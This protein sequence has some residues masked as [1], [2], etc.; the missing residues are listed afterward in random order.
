L[1]LSGADS[2]VQNEEHQGSD[3]LSASPGP[4]AGR[5][6]RALYPL[7]LAVAI[8]IW[9][10]AI[11]APLRIDE[12]GSYWQISKGFSEIVSRQG[13]LSFPAYSYIL[14][15]STKIIGT[16]EI[17]LRVPSILAM[18]GAVY[19][20]YLA[21][22]ELFER[23]IAFIAAVIFCLDPIVVF[24]SIDIRPYAF[25]VLATNAAIFVLLR[26]RHS[27]SNWLAALFG[28]MAASIVWFHFLFGVILPP[29]VLCFIAFKFR[30]CKTFWKQ[31]IV[32]SGAFALAFLPV[33]P[34]LIDMLRTSK[35]HVYEPA[36]NLSDLAMTLAPGW[37]F[38]VGCGIGFIAFL[39]HAVRPQ[40][41]LFNRFEGWLFLICASLGLLPILILYGVSAGTSLH[42][43]TYY[44]RLVAIPG[45]ALC[46]AFVLSRFH[47]RSLRLLFCLA[48][49]AATAYVYFTSPAT[50]RHEN[51][52]KYAIELAQRNASVD[53]AP[54]LMC[55][56]FVE[57]NFAAMPS[58][59]TVR[60]SRYFAPLS[61]YQLSVPVI[62]LPQ[63]INDETIQVG[64][65]F[66][67]EAAQKHERFLVV[68][69]KFHSYR[70]LDWFADHAART[71]SAHILGVFDGM[72]VMEFVPRASVAP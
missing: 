9:F 57:S 2:Q 29:L 54:V 23:D 53:D 66:L 44:H 69:D 1:Q 37:L 5:A 59:E 4:L 17:A 3:T 16:S 55:S 50:R 45:I 28:L 36:P 64:S 48:L 10:I 32:A 30:D 25:G 42:T 21:A 47:S 38:I 58:K 63:L 7:A 8:S 71:H 19:L 11:H 33:I 20:L 12:T 22:R 41:N 68:A 52:M 40:L 15:F 72:E 56:G 35:T 6:L 27:G 46:W 26:L 49:V 65:R 39:I 14:W 13:S 67:K 51:S 24:A 31:F 70:T 62:P 60:D 34:G 18:M 43:F 61:Y